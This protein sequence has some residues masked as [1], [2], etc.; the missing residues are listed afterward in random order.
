MVSPLGAVAGLALL[1]TAAYAAPPEQVH[2]AVA[3]PNS[4]TY[5]VMWWN[6][7]DEVELSQVSI[8]LDSDTDSAVMS[9]D[10]EASSLG[11]GFGS[12]STVVLPKLLPGNIYK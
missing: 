5:S 12:H 10:W 7:D 2:L 8:K 3:G 4:D 1:G 9:G 6:A 11:S